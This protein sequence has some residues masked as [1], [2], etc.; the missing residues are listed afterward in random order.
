MRYAEMHVPPAGRGESGSA[1]GSADGGVDGR[2]DGGVDGSA[3]GGVD[4][5]VDGSADGGVDGSADGGAE[6]GAD[7]RV[8]SRVVVVGRPGF[9]ADWAVSLPPE[10]ARAL[11]EAQNAGRTAVVV[12]WDGSARGVIVVAAA[13][14]ATSAEAISQLKALGLRPAAHR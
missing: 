4:G 11:D 5:G 13:V 8:V 14:K 3:D 9:V 6:G 2:A 7:G 10:L 12:A 1:N